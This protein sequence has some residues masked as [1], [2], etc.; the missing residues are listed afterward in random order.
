V[1]ANYC[2][3]GASMMSVDDE[4]VSRL[5]SLVDSSY[6]LS[7][8][9]TLAVATTP[10]G[11]LSSGEVD[12]FTDLSYQILLNIDRMREILAQIPERCD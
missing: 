12:A 10:P 3:A 8:V 7:S 2:G 4:R 6:E 9:L 1:A 11:E 5:V